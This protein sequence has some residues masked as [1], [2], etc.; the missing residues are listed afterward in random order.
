VWGVN[1]VVALDLLPDDF[2]P[3]IGYP[4]EQ[5]LDT[6]KGGM[7]KDEVRSVLGRPHMQTDGG[8]DEWTYVPEQ[9]TYRCDFFGGALFRVYF[10]PDGRVVSREWWL[11]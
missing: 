4:P 2:R 5:H 1:A 7:S 8:Q 10:G 11:N 9:W 6:I 3:G